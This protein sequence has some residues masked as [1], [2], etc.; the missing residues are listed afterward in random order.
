MGNEV[1][2]FALFGLEEEQPETLEQQEKKDGGET[3]ENAVNSGEGEEDTV[4][5]EQD[6]DDEGMDDHD[7]AEEDAEQ[8]AQDGAEEAERGSEGEGTKGE[9]TPLSAEQKRKN[10]A[11]RR[12]REI[13]QAREQARQEEREKFARREKEFFARAKL[14]NQYDPEKKQL[15]S[16]D[17]FDKWYRTHQQMQ[18]EQQLKQ[19]QLTPEALEEA[20]RRALEAQQ[21]EMHDGQMVQRRE[22]EQKTAFEQ[23]VKRQMEEIRKMDPNMESLED[24][25]DSPLGKDFEDA[26]NDGA[27]FLAA[28]RTAKRLAANQRSAA[29]IQKQTVRQMQGKQ[30]LQSHRGAGA[31]STDL[32]V[33]PAVI[34]NY[35]LFDPKISMAEI[36]ADYNK[37]MKG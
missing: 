28:Y 8:Q 15:E 6:P 27:S 14:T 26:V 1:N 37:R 23:E 18:M 21:S 30:H 12:R 32:E 17:D 20:A 16:Y 22:N 7:E 35:R 4:G 11:R 31:A 3:V 10:A 19:G 9:K 13:E 25:L 24:I 2:Y 33:P 34:R 5:R 36:K 29:A